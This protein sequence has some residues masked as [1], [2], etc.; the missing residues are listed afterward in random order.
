MKLKVKKLH[1][2]AIL[3]TY[4]K[5][6]DAGMDLYALEAFTVFVNEVKHVKTGIAV[7]IPEGYVGYVHSRSGLA[8]K[9]GVYVPNGPGVID[10]G[11]RGE[12]GVLLSYN[13]Q[14][15]VGK[16]NPINMV[17]SSKMVG[18]KMVHDMA[19]GVSFAKG[20]RI[21]QLVV[22]SFTTADL[23]EVHSLDETERGEGGFGHTG[24]KS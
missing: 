15:E 9:K 6:G 5:S 2:D 1:Q 22:Q 16:P 8:M 3:P 17:K 23:E 24:V 10:S 11:Y 12:V 4:A 21:A 18:N 14:A 19:L 13:G 20:D 7:Q